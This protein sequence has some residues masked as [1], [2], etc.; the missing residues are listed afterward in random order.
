[1]KRTICL[2]AL[3]ALL[4]TGCGQTTASVQETEAVE[5]ETVETAE[6][7]EA[8]ETVEVT[9]TAE[10]EEIAEAEETAEPESEVLTFVDDLGREVTVSDPQRVAALIGSFADIWCLA[11]GQDVLVAAAHDTWTSFDLGLGDEVADLGGVSEPSLETLL[12]AEPDLVLASCN[13]DADVELLE[14]LEDAGIPVAYFAVSSFPEY[15]NMLDICT[16]ITGQRDRYET[17]GTALQQEIDDAKATADGS[18]PTVLYIRAT[19][20]SCKVKNSEDSVLGEMLAD[21][22]CVNIADSDTGLLENLSMEAILADD[23]DYVFVVLQGS[24]STKAEEML[25]ETLLSNPAWESLTAV[26]EGRYYVLDNA[27]YNLKPNARWGEAYTK[28]AEILYGTP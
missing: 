21:L 16:A 3:A 24:D 18:Q 26:Q 28:L 23:P 20:S 27:L 8:A 12:A 9:E 25:N 11:G 22:D 5:T 13:T 10:P 15:L 19:G 4:L 17:Y 14:T 2:F 1:M 6:V 7:T